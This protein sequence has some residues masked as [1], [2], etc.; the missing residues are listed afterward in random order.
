MRMKQSKHMTT[1]LLILGFPMF[2][3]L[4]DGYMIR[5]ICAVEPVRV[6]SSMAPWTT[7]RMSYP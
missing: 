5:Y 3:L 2:Y 4:Q 7:G 6:G 1:V